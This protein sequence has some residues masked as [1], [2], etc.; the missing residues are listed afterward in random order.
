VSVFE[1]YLIIQQ[2]V[3]ALEMKTGG[4]DSEPGVEQPCIATIVG[5]DIIPTHHY[6]NPANAFL[7][8]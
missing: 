5:A 4:R 6:R 8:S 3:F 1:Y 7:Y 2:R